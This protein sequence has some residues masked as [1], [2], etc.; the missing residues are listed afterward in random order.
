VRR[1]QALRTLLDQEPLQVLKNTAVMAPMTYRTCLT[2]LFTA[3]I[4]ILSLGRW[5][6]ADDDIR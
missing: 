4:G 3:A 5:G 6:I 1:D 2:L